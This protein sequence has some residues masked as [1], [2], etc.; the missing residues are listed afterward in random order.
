MIKCKTCK[1]CGLFKSLFEFHRSKIHKDGYKTVC[2]A[3]RKEELH[4]YYLKNKEK[5]QNRIRQ[6][7]LR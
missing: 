1:K 4:F 2:K 6:Y 7:S 5:I 3:C